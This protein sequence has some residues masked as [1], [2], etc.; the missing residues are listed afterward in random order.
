MIGKFAE[1]IAAWLIRRE[2]IEA[3]DRELYV[4]A[5]YSLLVTI[6]P[7]MLSMLMGMIMGKL[8]DSLR[9]VFPFMVIRK[10]S[11]GY[12]AKHPWTCFLCS[13]M[14]LFICILTASNIKCSVPFA[15]ITACA[16]ISLVMFSPIDSE[17]RRLEQ[18]EKKRYRTIAA[19]LSIGFFC[20]C[21][22]FYALRM[23]SCTICFS[24]GLILTAG[25]Q[26][27]C[28]FRKLLSKVSSSG[29]F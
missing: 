2:A 15:V 26:I 4:Y 9:I 3:S 5:A 6:F 10:Y 13:C 11:G 8:L 24:A 22:V 21:P 20:S 14:L 27:P 19:L 18:T 12:H 17:D 1:R 7:I 29:C 25:L 28:I 23:Y 16:A